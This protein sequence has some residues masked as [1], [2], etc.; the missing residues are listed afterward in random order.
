MDRRALLKTWA[1]AALFTPSLARAQVMPLGRIRA[2]PDQIFRVTVCTRPF[3]AAGPRIETET[4]G[5]KIVVHNYGHGGSG[6][7]LSWGSADAAVR[8][9]MQSS[10]KHVAIVGAGALGL[11]AA[12]TAQRAGA[13][14]TVYAKERFPF[15][16]SAR[17][18]GVWT[19]DS[20]IAMKSAAAPDFGDRWEAMARRSWAMHQAYVGLPGNPVEWIDQYYTHTGRPEYASLPGNPAAEDFLALGDRLADTVPHSQPVPNDQHPFASERVTRA[21]VL[22]FNVADLAHQLTEDFLMAGGRFEALELQ[23]PHDVTKLKQPVVINCTGY[24]ARDLWNDTSIIPVRGQ[25]AWLPPQDDAHYSFSYQSTIVVGRRDGIVVQ[26]V[27]P[28]DLFGWND[29]NET[30]DIEAAKR[31]V[32][33]IAGAYRT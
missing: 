20:R 6:W 24:A 31:S 28:D 7:S 9:A 2:A 33:L 25:I 4:V 1:A 18:T 22:S 17:A 3:R 32:A 13:Q 8:L 21:R 19:P 29:P 15:V 10:P 14:V 11:T 16:R 30:P 26:D 5:R 27:G 23:S 12:V